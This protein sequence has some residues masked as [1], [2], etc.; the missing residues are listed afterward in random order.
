MKIFKR[1]LLVLGILVALL[2]VVVVGFIY[3]MKSETKN[4]K[5]LATKEVVSNIF[6]VNDSFVNMYVVVP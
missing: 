4:M 3:K 6:S 5:P 2:V 1:L